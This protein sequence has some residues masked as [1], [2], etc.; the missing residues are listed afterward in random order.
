MLKSLI[1]NRFIAISVAFVLGCTAFLGINT[2]VSYA[3]NDN[4][5]F[6]FTIKPLGQ[7]TRSSGQY[8]ET[9]NQYNA[10]KVN[11]QNSNEASGNTVTRF[12][13]EGYNKQNVSPSP[14]VLEGSGAHYYNTYTSASQRTVYLTAQDN[15]LNLTATYTASGVWDEETGILLN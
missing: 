15:D 13:L 3:G 5:N 1:S 10:W 8:R 4:I 9:T 6:S 14:D 11:L 2:L 7:N 12:W